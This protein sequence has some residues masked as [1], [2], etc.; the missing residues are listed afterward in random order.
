MPML[1]DIV[2]RVTATECNWHKVFDGSCSRLCTVKT[3]VL[4]LETW[5]KTLWASLNITTDEHKWCKWLT[6]ASSGV[7]QVGPHRRN[8]AS[9]H[10]IIKHRLAWK[11]NGRTGLPAGGQ[12]NDNQRLQR[13]A[14]H[15][16]TS[17]RV[18]AAKGDY[19]CDDRRC[20]R[21]RQLSA[22][23]FPAGPSF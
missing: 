13:C 18:M 21:H 3:I 12:E 2:W 14:Q 22:E 8:S 1:A 20:G 6:T 10:Q 11:G 16:A 23:Y 7:G 9:I 4:G 15:L 5:V 19:N 17:P